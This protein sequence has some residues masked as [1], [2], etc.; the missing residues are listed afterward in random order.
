MTRALLNTL[1]IGLVGTLAACRPAQKDPPFNF[2]HNRQ[3]A[4]VDTLNIDAKNPLSAM[5]VPDFWK[6]ST[7]KSVDGSRVKIALVGSGVD[8][9]NPDIR[10]A[11]WIN[12]AEYSEATRSNGLDDDGNGYNDDFSGFD[13]ASGDNLPYDWNGHDTFTASLIAA[14]AR[15]NA[16]IVG[17]APNA[18]LIVARYIGSDGR[19]KGMDAVEALNYAVVNQAKVIYFNWSEGGFS[20]LETPLVVEAIKEAVAKNIVV[21]TPAGNSANQAIPAF[22]KAIAQIPGVV[23]VAGVDTEGKILRSSNSGKGLATTA[24]PIFGALAYLPGGEMTQDIQT[25]SVAAAYVAGIAALLS[26]LPDLG[27]AQRIQQ[28]LLGKAVDRRAPRR[29][30]LDVLSNS[31]VYIGGL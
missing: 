31:P 26:T 30:P 9:T 29:E 8:Y 20:A 21:V 1:V 23:V 5:G 10:D 2:E 3:D 14:T 7:G 16:K 13:F 18:E 4:K 19:G 6:R 25:T 28:A 27:S 12:I 22:L 15:A 17:V 24:A 11:L